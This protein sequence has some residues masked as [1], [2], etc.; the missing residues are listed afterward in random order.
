MLSALKKANLSD[1]IL[2]DKNTEYQLWHLLYSVE[3]RNE[4]IHALNGFAQRHNLPEDFVK[5]FQKI[6]S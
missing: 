6:P 3:D 1:A 5:A 4:L 2:Q